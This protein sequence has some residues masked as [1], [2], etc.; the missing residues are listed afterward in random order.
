MHDQDLRIAHEQHDRLEIP[1]DVIGQV[2]VHVRIRSESVEGHH[3]RVAVRGDFASCAVAT[4][5]PEATR[6]STT[7][8]CPRASVSLG[9]TSRAAK[10]DAPPGLAGTNMCTG[11]T[12]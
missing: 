12:G 3:D 1:D 11:F 7:K 6:F 2:L 4:M 10:S 9:A 5:P 8:G